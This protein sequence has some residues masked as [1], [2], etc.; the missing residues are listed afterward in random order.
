[1]TIA[2]ATWYNYNQTKKFFIHNTSKKELN[3]NT[4]LTG[5]N[6][7][8]QGENHVDLFEHVQRQAEKTIFQTLLSESV[9]FSIREYNRKTDTLDLL[10]FSAKEH[11]SIMPEL[12]DSIS[13]EETAGGDAFKGNRKIYVGNISISKY[14]HDN[15]LILW[16]AGYKSMLAL[17]L[18]I[19]DKV[20]GVIQIYTG[21]ENYSFDEKAMLTISE[22]CALVVL[23]I[24]AEKN[25]KRNERLTKRLHRNEKYAMIG[26]HA[27]DITHE[28]GNKVN[29]IIGG[30]AFQTKSALLREDGHMNTPTERGIE[31]AVRNMNRILEEI[32]TFMDSTKNITEYGLAKNQILHI[33]KADIFGFARGIVD[34][35]NRGDVDIKLMKG[36]L[37][38][39]R[40][41]FEEILVGFDKGQMDSVICELLENARLAV[42]NEDEGNQKIILRVYKYREMDR[43]SIC[44][45]IVNRGLIPE[46][47][48]KRIFDPFFTT[49]TYGSG[50]G[51]S[52]A[53]AKVRSHGGIIK[54]HSGCKKVPK[55][56]TSFRVYLPVDSEVNSSE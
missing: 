2:T 19:E 31:I 54:V 34:L 43:D 25:H 36:D 17:P 38:G 26:L 11:S 53:L 18:Y 41:D 32:D 55:G 21:V 45:E 35:F 4:F 8:N 28:I 37:S 42:K 5:D 29:Q 16:K 48:L 9:L 30:L 10:L 46:N 23:M 40:G 13:L 12:E 20:M 1:L 14:Y 50:L 56:C 15:G 51:L 49:R 3:M 22:F 24:I 6:S 44:I 47:D 33:E 7:G 27:A 39:M 52:L